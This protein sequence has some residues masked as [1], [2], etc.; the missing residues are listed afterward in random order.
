[1]L[2][3]KKTAFPDGTAVL[4]LER[5]RLDRIR[6]MV[7][8]TDTIVTKRSWGYIGDDDF[9]SADQLVDELVDIVSKNGVLLLNVGPMADGTIPRKTSDI[10]IEIG[11]WLDVNGEAIYQSRPWHTFGEGPHLVCERERRS[12]PYEPFT[13]EDIR[14][15]TRAGNIYV[16]CLDWPD[17]ELKVESLSSRTFLSSNGISD[18]QLLGSAQKL[19]WSQDGTG[20]TIELPSEMPCKYAFVFKIILNRD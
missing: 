18:V 15:T 1:M 5:E 3:Y 2:N 12:R 4:D 17:K 9:K 7:W 8:Q 11:S 13:A 14:F 6:E 16:I 19:K 10:L 20:L